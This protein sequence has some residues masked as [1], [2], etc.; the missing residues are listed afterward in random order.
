MS[1]E[2][3]E[4]GKN[5]IK[6]RISQVA[7]LLTK[8]QDQDVISQ[9]EAAS[10]V[11][12]CFLD[13]AIAVSKHDEI[14]AAHRQKRDEIK[15]KKEAGDAAANQSKDFFGGL[16][17]T[18][19]DIAASVV[20]TVTDTAIDAFEAALKVAA[21][22]MG[23]LTQGIFNG[24]FYFAH[25][26]NI[27]NQG[28]NSWSIAIKDNVSRELAA[29][30]MQFAQD[31]HDNFEIYISNLDP[32][33]STALFR[34]TPR[35][36]IASAI[37][38]IKGNIKFYDYVTNEKPV[39]TG[40][41]LREQIEVRFDSI[42]SISEK[43]FEIA[44]K[45]KL[46]KE[47]TDYCIQ[48]TDPSD[49]SE[50]A[51]LSLPVSCMSV[52]NNKNNKGYFEFINQ[53]Y[54][55]SLRPAGYHSI[56]LLFGLVTKVNEEKINSEDNTIK[57]VK[58]SY[59]FSKIQAPNFDYLKEFVDQ[60]NT[61]VNS[62]SNN[63]F[64]KDLMN[65]L[66]S[67]VRDTMDKIITQKTVDN[68]FDDS[69][70][71]LYEQYMLL[72][73]L[74]K[75]KGENKN[76]LLEQE[77]KIYVNILKEYF[78]T[79]DFIP[80][81]E[82][83][84]Q[85]AN[86]NKKFIE[87][88]ITFIKELT[89][90]NKFDN[91]T[92]VN[93]NKQ[94]MHSAFF[95]NLTKSQ[96][97]KA[98]YL[99]M[100]ELAKTVKIC[101]DL[102]NDEVANSGISA[103][104]TGDLIDDLYYKT[105][106]QLSSLT[107]KNDYELLITAKE[108]DAEIEALIKFKQLTTGITLK[109]EY[110]SQPIVNSSSSSQLSSLTP[111]IQESDNS[112]LQYYT[113]LTTSTTAITH[114]TATTFSNP[115][116]PSND[117]SEDEN[118]DTDAHNAE[119]SHIEINNSEFFTRPKTEAQ[120]K[121][122]QAQITADLSNSTH[123][124]KVTS[125]VINILEDILNNAKDAGIK[126]D[127][128]S[129]NAKPQAQKSE[130]SKSPPVVIEKDKL[131]KTQP[132][133]IPN[134]NKPKKQD[135]IVLIVENNDDNFQEESEDIQPINEDKPYAE[136]DEYLT[137]FREGELNTPELHHAA[138]KEFVKKIEPLENVNAFVGCEDIEELKQLKIVWSDSNIATTIDKQYKTNF[139]SI[140]NDITVQ[141]EAITAKKK[142][143]DR[144]AKNDCKN[145]FALVRN[146][147]DKNN[148]RKILK[149]IISVAPDADKILSSKY[150]VRFIALYGKHPQTYNNLSAIGELEH[151]TRESWTQSTLINSNNI[152]NFICHI[153]YKRVS[154]DA[155]KG[156]NIDSFGNGT[157]S[158]IDNLLFDQESLQVLNG[159]HRFKFYT[160]D[161]GDQ[162]HDDF[163][164]YCNQYKLL[165]HP[166]VNILKKKITTKYT[167]VSQLRDLINLVAL[168]PQYL[169][170]L[171]ND[172]DP[173]FCFKIFNKL[174]DFANNQK[175]LTPKLNSSLIRINAAIVYRIY[176]FVFNKETISNK[177]EEEK[178][179]TLSQLTWSQNDPLSLEKRNFINCAYTFATRISLPNINRV[180][181]VLSL[182]TASFKSTNKNLMPGIVNLIAEYRNIHPENQELIPRVF[183]D[184][185]ARQYEHPESKKNTVLSL[186]STSISERLSP[187]LDEDNN[188]DNDFDNIVSIKE[189]NIEAALAELFS[190]NYT[191]HHL[192]ELVSCYRNDLKSYHLISVAI[193]SLTF[194]QAWDLRLAIAANLY[195]KNKSTPPYGYS[196]LSRQLIELLELNPEMK[197]PLE[198]EKNYRNIF[199]A[200]QEQILN[201]AKNKSWKVSSTF[202]KSSNKVLPNNKNYNT[203]TYKDFPTY[204]NQMMETMSCVRQ[205]TLSSRE[206]FVEL[207]KINM[208]ALNIEI[209]G[210]RSPFT[211]GFYS[212]DL[213]FKYLKIDAKTAISAIK[214]YISDNSDKF[215]AINLWGVP[216]G[217][218]DILDIINDNSNKVT[219]EEKLIKILKIAMK[220]ANSMN[221][222]PLRSSFTRHFYE[223]AVFSLLK[224]A[225]NKMK[226]L[227]KT[228]NKNSDDEYM[229]AGYQSE[230][231]AY[232]NDLL[233][234]DEKGAIVTDKNKRASI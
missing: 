74:N 14:L 124:K 91:E 176:T 207:I 32:D 48:I 132:L 31:F 143:E 127:D 53:D 212:R 168:N 166:V 72:E 230:P 162:I 148:L 196:D 229:A 123:G 85:D 88:C 55:L 170:F 57:L 102:H 158:E 200:L 163:S 111:S 78:K 30:M 52:D 195:E 79:H 4:N 1:V 129:N 165:S 146:K 157:Q 51:V 67:R 223:H 54:R 118:T 2:L 104:V 23:P 86:A 187:Q 202:F 185:I 173:Y 231:E 76:A 17:K 101:F 191:I 108:K 18:F 164:Y 21:N 211:S 112:N 44:A 109:Y 83:K 19:T 89:T 232:N 96:L 125:E 56:I 206:A 98:P 184:E 188:M 100:F 5:R 93:L 183:I 58:L 119:E 177:T 228:S 233:G 136:T 106:D 61:Y 37:S 205:F 193:N 7:A 131:T 226:D 87:G 3:S 122:I 11:L 33:K 90:S 126:T 204:V 39:A 84:L 36:T 15:K 63:K 113:T 25:L 208:R 189:N 150:F 160:G 217:V 234:E 174:I 201:D 80:L 50:N 135:D 6:E 29:I 43:P 134:P 38:Q 149:R 82:K 145:L 140:R 128:S 180:M 68:Y 130:D 139:L 22:Q 117:S 219:P 199:R 214:N 213:L 138:I 227:Q 147:H 172:I 169:N 161:K 45:Q 20:N 167:P 133:T 137:K 159:N 8:T 175:S 73:K 49:D 35:K 97:F 81:L 47:L 116:L 179:D 197:V 12:N 210:G 71:S 186:Q 190:M 215:N 222:S 114:S 92:Y 194:Q 225:P 10:S 28:N 13:P 95:G 107:G 69:Y 62:G 46:L 198:E 27:L 142:I 103:G 209:T 171:K 155:A 120:P 110:Y 42:E 224:Y 178:L 9:I 144:L 24:R 221:P 181:T 192:L 70:Q 26:F 105:L 151:F 220:S 75:Y 34:T 154:G 216:S 141:I 77:T 121:N 152:L 16:T 218:G 66:I 41:A 153:H 203:L 60:A 156:K 64:K 99:G 40:S 182:L 65:R 115:S 59:W 94:F